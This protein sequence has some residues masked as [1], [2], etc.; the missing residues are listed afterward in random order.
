VTKKS[1]GKKKGGSSQTS[2]TTEWDTIATLRLSENCNKIETIWLSQLFASWAPAEC[3]TMHKAIKNMYLRAKDSGF[4]AMTLAIQNLE[5]HL[6]GL[7]PDGA[8]PPVE[9]REEINAAVYVLKAE[10]KRVL[11]YQTKGTPLVRTPANIYGDST[12]RLFGDNSSTEFELPLVYLIDSD[13]KQRKYLPLQM[14]QQ[15][16]KIRT[17]RSIDQFSQAFKDKK[18]HLIISD[19]VFPE[20]NM[21]GIT[22]ISRLNKGKGKIPLIFISSRADITARFMAMRTGGSDAFLMKPVDVPSLLNTMDQLVGYRTQ[23]IYKILIVEQDEDIAR[24]Y[25]FALEQK[26]M[27]TRLIHQAFEIMTSIMSYKPDAIVIDQI[28][29]ECTGLELVRLVRQEPMFF[30]LPIIYLSEKNSREAKIQAM[31]AGADEFL[32]KTHAE[33][34]LAPIIKN[35]I[36]RANASKQHLNYLKTRDVVT[37]LCNLEFFATQL[38]QWMRTPTSGYS[39]VILVR[40]DH[41]VE[42]RGILGFSGTHHLIADISAII[43]KIIGQDDLLARFTESG[44]VVLCRRKETLPLVNLTEIIK[45]S[46]EKYTP[47]GQDRVSSVSASISAGLCD[48]IDVDTLLAELEASVES[49][50]RKGGNRVHLLDSLTRKVANSKPKDNPLNALLEKIGAGRFQLCY[51]P[52]I[53]TEV[54]EDQRYEVL[55]KVLGKSGDSAAVGKLMQ[56]AERAGIMDKID[57]QIIRRSLKSIQTMGYQGK[58]VTLFV[59]I[60]KAS[61]EPAFF[62][63]LIRSAFK[64]TKVR[65]D[66][67]VF[68]LDTA[69]V[70]DKL[71]DMKTLLGQLHALGCKIGLDNFGERATDDQLLQQFPVDFVRLDASTTENLISDDLKSGKLKDLLK[72]VSSIG[73]K[74]IVGGIEDAIVLNQVWN[75]NTD[76][77]QGA[78]IQAPEDTMEFD[79]VK[80]TETL[81]FWT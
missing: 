79:F 63:N 11:E 33:E 54:D 69:A 36:I 49:A 61:L 24:E 18:P 9:Q 52:L 6:F 75:L 66:A 30:N 44:F 14:S 56:A 70:W 73:A 55:L 58:N 31:D 78:F 19:V 34:L 8:F 28:L 4:N 43:K 38:A 41:F 23:D 25:S 46:I 76:L 50:T 67:L 81:C 68:L 40:L 77:L 42:L 62:L 2:T 48:E 72:Y 15:G 17:F 32:G 74:S 20:G 53:R 3:A 5:L 65:K 21:T 35:R 45:T 1:V 64:D 16:Y 57:R 22:A 39:S 59:R 80:E 10:I 51:Q 47:R 12:I 60:S 27:S 7:L 29:P 71:D 37:G 26:G 13:A